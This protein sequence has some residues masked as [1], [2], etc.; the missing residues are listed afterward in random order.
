MINYPRIIKILSP[1]IRKSGNLILLPKALENLTLG[2]F[3]IPDAF[4]AWIRLLSSKDCVEEWYYK[5]VF[6]GRIAGRRYPCI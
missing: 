6:F 4:E 3:I 2:F 1:F 5:R